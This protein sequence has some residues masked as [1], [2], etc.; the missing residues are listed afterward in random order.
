MTA[1]LS[2]PTDVG[3]DGSITVMVWANMELSPNHD[4]YEIVVNVF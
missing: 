3:W 2:G 1:Q 4:A